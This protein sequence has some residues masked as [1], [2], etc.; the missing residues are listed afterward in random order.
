VVLMIPM[1]LSVQLVPSDVLPVL[2]LTTVSS[3]QE[4]EKV[5][6]NVD[7]QLDIMNTVMDHVNNV[8]INVSTVINTL[9]I[10]PH[11][12]VTESTNQIVIV[13]SVIMKTIKT[14]TVHLVHIIVENVLLLD[15]LL[16]VEIE[17][18]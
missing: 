4:S 11:V 13:H 1:K 15:V 3:V 5:L 16:V 10:V 18:C 14:L 8:P 2:I 6:Q 9:K 7:A 17:L 12:P